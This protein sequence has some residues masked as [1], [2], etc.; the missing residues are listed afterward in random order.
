MTRIEVRVSDPFGTAIFGPGL[1]AIGGWTAGE[2][3]RFQ[4]WYRDPAGP[5]GTGFNTT[6]GLEV[7]FGR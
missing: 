4:V 5:C 6:H 3:R 1:G 2:T 7:T